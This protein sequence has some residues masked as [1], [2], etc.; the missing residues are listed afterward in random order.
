MKTWAERDR[1]PVP[2]L[3]VPGDLSLRGD[4]GGERPHSQERPSV[5]AEPPRLTV[6]KT[7]P[8]SIHSQ[9][10]EP[11]GFS[12]GLLCGLESVMEPL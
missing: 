3:G 6:P 2:R 4:G 8:L 7:Q 5:G 12:P 10:L 1:T 9:A 11:S